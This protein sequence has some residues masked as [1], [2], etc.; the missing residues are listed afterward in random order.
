MK[1]RSPEQTTLDKIFFISFFIATPI[2]FSCNRF[3]FTALCFRLSDVR[4]H[5][6][7]FPVRLYI[8][9]VALLDVSIYDVGERL[10]YGVYPLEADYQA[11]RRAFVENKRRAR[12]GIALAAHKNTGLA[13]PDKVHRKTLRADISGV[14]VLLPLHLYGADGKVSIGGGKKIA[15]FFQLERVCKDEFSAHGAFCAVCI[16]IRMFACGRHKYGVIR[17]FKRICLVC[18]VCHIFF[19]RSNVVDSQ[20][21]HIAADIFRGIVESNIRILMQS[22]MDTVSGVGVPLA[23]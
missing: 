12:P 3:Y 22:E 9:S 8:G 10:R 14:S 6:A 21:S 1:K 13:F 19:Y 11:P 4:L 15:S 2:P 23:V 18:L 5:D 17:A 20:I 16:V 7:H